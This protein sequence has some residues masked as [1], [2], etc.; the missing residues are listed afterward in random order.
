[1]KC[2][3]AWILLAVACSTAGAAELRVCADPNNLPFSN[4]AGAGFENRIVELLARDLGANVTYTWWAQ[5]RGSLRN[6]LQARKCDVVPGIASGIE[7][8]A[9][10]Q[11]YYRSSYQFV[12][13]SDGPYA[14]IGSFD[15]PRLQRAMIGVQL[16]GD[17]GANTPP[18]HA[19]AQRGMLSNVRGFMVYGDYTDE[20]PQADILNAVVDGRIDVAVVW[21]PTAGYYAVRSA[22][23]LR[24]H[25]AISPVASSALPMS[26]AVAMGVRPD[27]HALLQTLNEAL[28]RNRAGIEAILAEYGVPVQPAP[29]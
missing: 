28:Q 10:T 7:R 11:P 23:P 19:L 3:C 12:A 8:V 2:M 13:R 6:T 15:D 5:R 27:D 9:T 20:F 25:P 26:F 1:M 17:D 21:G 24:L 14:E 16:V 22:R 29:E 4:R 18:A